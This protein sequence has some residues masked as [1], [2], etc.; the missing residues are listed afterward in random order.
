MGWEGLLS[1]GHWGVIDSQQSGNLVLGP[2]HLF[3]NEAPEVALEKANW[4]N[5][6]AEK[7]LAVSLGLVL[8]R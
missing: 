8:R 6:E 1:W 7:T 2:S 3:P 5:G 4:V